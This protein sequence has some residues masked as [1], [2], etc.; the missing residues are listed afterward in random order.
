MLCVYTL[1]LRG[2]VTWDPRVPR[3]RGPQRCIW[4]SVGVDMEEVIL[5]M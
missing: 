2:L 4:P 3:G 5:S 1:R